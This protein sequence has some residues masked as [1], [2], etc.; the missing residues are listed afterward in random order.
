MIAIALLATTA[1]SAV[2]QIDSV[3]K[4]IQTAFSSLR[5]LSQVMV[6][7]NG[8]DQFGSRT[9]VLY[10][11]AYY[12]WNPSL[13][14]ALARAEINDTLNN[15]KTRRIAGDGTVLWAYDFYRNIYTS[16]KYGAYTGAQPKDYRTNLFDQLNASAQGP[17]VFLSRFLREVY[18]GDFA[19]YRTWLPMSTITEV[20]MTSGTLTMADPVNP[21]RMYVADNLNMYV[22]YSYKT[23]PTRSGAFHLTRPDTTTQWGLSEFFYSDRQQINVSNV[24]WI[25]W[26]MTINT[27][28]YQWFTDFSFM[29]PKTARA[30]ASLRGQ[31]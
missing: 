26:T 22:V 28:P 21:N 30:V 11:N 27:G 20:S 9:N 14:D 17:S 8:T 10:S 12:A 3:E 18:A 7:L 1:G 2:A 15:A 16:Y 29:P 19:Q 4:P 24:R 25:D 6:E 23:R 31:G 13:P 5:G